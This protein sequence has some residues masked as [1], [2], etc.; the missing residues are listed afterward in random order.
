MADVDVYKQWGDAVHESS[1][2][3]GFTGI[4]FPFQFQLFS[5]ASSLAA[6]SGRNA[7]FWLKVL[8]LVGDLGILSLLLISAP[9]RRLSVVLLY[10]INPWFVV[11]FTQGYCDFQLSLFLLSSM[12]LSRSTDPRSS[13]L[14]GIP[15]GMAFLMK[16][17]AMVVLFGIGLFLAL[18]LVLMRPRWDAFLVLISPGIVFVGYSIYFWRHGRPLLFLEE[19]YLH[20]S[21]IMPA[22]TANMLNVWYPLALIA[23]P[24]QPIWQLRDDVAF[25]G[26]ILRTIAMTATIALIALYGLIAARGTRRDRPALPQ[27]IV[28]TTLVLPMVMSSSHENHLFFATVGIAFLLLTDDAR[29]ARWVWI[30]FIAVVTVQTINL[31]GLYG[32]GAN[33]LS[34]WTLV[35]AIQ[36]FWQARAPRLMGAAIDIAGFVVLNNYCCDRAAAEPSVRRWWTRAPALLVTGLLIAIYVT[37]IASLPRLRA[38]PGIARIA[39]STSHMA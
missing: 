27:L 13:F 17:Q 36:T 25:W 26:T 8:N 37:A 21:S 2:A 6:H 39:A 31:I 9:Q 38:T 15:L 3:A 30:A 18:S 29:I 35:K 22:L 32:L 11:L 23:K 24:G 4:Y 19:S 14:A 10:W 5:L 1:L 34:E 20:T 16:P 28:Y 33:R 7:F 12:V